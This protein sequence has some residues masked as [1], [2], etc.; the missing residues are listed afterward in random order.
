MQERS[1]SLRKAALAAT[2]A[3]TIGIWAVA[4]WAWL[5]PGSSKAPISAPTTVGTRIPAVSDLPDRDSHALPT[6]QPEVART[7]TA[8]DRDPQAVPA[9]Q[10]SPVKS[11]PVSSKTAEK[12]PPALPAP[13]SSPPVEAAADNR[14][15]AFGRTTLP[16][17]DTGTSVVRG[18]QASLPSEVASDG[19][20]AVVRG[21]QGPSALPMPPDSGPAVVRGTRATSGSSAP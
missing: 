8:T 18:I 7:V 11:P 3:A 19:N 4:M 14:A 21:K 12:D 20:T 1:T 15:H 16:L 2:L 10:P 6:P 13:Q 5:G 9:L 17:H